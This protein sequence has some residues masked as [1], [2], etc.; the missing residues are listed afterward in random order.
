MLVKIEERILIFPGTDFHFPSTSVPP[1]S[2]CR[3]T[4]S[5]KALKALKPTK[6]GCYGNIPRG[7]EKL[8]SG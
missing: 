6:F 7:T 5:V 3:P 2:A 4:N 8:I 1:G